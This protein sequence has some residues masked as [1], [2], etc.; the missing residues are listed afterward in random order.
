MDTHVI[1]V[2]CAFAALVISALSF[3][4]SSSDRRIDERIDLKLKADIAVIKV[5]LSTIKDS[6]TRQSA[7]AAAVVRAA[8]EATADSIREAAESIADAR[9]RA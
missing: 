8:V 7:Q 9:T 3:F 5:D 4:R 2:F 1:T 6:V